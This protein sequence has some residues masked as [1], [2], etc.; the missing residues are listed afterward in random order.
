MIEMIGPL[1]MV[2]FGVI[3]LVGGTVGHTLR[4]RRRA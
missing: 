3:A 4:E 2:A 1:V